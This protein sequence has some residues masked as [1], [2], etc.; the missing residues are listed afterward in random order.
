[1]TT[2]QASSAAIIKEMFKV[3]CADH[4]ASD[5]KIKLILVYR[6]ATLPDDEDGKKELAEAEKS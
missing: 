6:N 2:A 5:G 1:M 3:H 4:E